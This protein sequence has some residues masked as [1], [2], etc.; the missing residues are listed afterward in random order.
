MLYVGQDNIKQQIIFEIRYHLTQGN[1]EGAFT[2]IKSMSV[3]KDPVV[4][5]EK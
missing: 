2:I 3:A 1:D 5:P 4:R